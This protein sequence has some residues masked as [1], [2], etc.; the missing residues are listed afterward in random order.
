[1]DRVV[2]LRNG[3][4]KELVGVLHIPEESG[5]DKRKVGIHLLN[6]GIKYRVAPNRLNVK[7]ARALCREGY[8]VLR[9]DPE[10]IGDSE[11]ELEE[12]VMVGEIFERIQTG[13]FVSDAVA[14]NDLMVNDYEI[15]EIIMMGNCGGAITSLLASEVDERV[16]GMCLIDVPIVLRS[17]SMSFAD[18]IVQGGKRSDVMFR[19][20]VCKAFSATAW[21]RFLSLKSDY[22]GLWKIV[23]TQL[24]KRGLLPQARCP[25][26]VVSRS[27]AQK[28]SST[29]SSLSPWTVP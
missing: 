5:V 27:Y 15:E 19:A 28:G 14:C 25:C 13:M 16:V 2:S 4:G 1:M 7:I 22:R 3:N 18:R 24:Q 6:P 20:Y 17:P 12:G 23:T 21:Y 9:V 10:G 8:Y 26:R 29:R 11:G